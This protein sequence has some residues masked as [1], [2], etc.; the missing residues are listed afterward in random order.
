MK[1]PVKPNAQDLTF[2]EYMLF[3]AKYASELEKYCDELEENY[4]RALSDVVKYT[5]A[6]E[7]ALLALSVRI[8]MDDPLY[9]YDDLKEWVFRGV[10]EGLEDE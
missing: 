6:L 10:S 7:K 1:R 3:S 9:D 4:E 2:E 5:M 8:D